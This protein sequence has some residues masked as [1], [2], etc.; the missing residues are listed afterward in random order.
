MAKGRR[1][2]WKKE[3]EVIEV[4]EVEEEAFEHDDNDDDKEDE[5]SIA[6]RSLHLQGDELDAAT[7]ESSRVAARRIGR[8]K[9][10]VSERERKRERPCR[11][12]TTSTEDS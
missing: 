10:A 1:C 2:W 6:S 12:V 7:L 8:E 5:A 4:E 3:R 11:D 9:G